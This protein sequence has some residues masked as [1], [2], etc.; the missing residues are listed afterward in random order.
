SN[1]YVF[2]DSLSDT[3]NFSL[4]TG[5]NQPP[6]SSPGYSNGQWITDLAS[7]LGLSAVASGLVGGTNYAYGGAL[8]SGPSVV[9]GFTV[10]SVADQIQTYLASAPGGHADG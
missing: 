4:A 9:D 2:G 6:A 5:G 3:G 8:I 10:P 7:H 1:L